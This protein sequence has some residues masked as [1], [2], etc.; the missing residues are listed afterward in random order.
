MNSTTGEA[1]APVRLVATLCAMAIEVWRLK[2]R[3]S[4]ALPLLPP[5]EGR[6][7]ETSVLRLEELLLEARVTIDDPMGRPYTDGERHQVLLFEPRADV[8]RPT[9]AQTVKPA[10]FVDGVLFKPAEVI[11]ATPLSAGVA[12]P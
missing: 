11:V 10:V 8:A 4:R 9:V 1:L 12:A 5:K 6:P 7:L 3:S 2:S